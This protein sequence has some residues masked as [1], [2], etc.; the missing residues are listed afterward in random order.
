MSL[1]ISAHVGLTS[2]GNGT[3]R[4]HLAAALD[5]GAVDVG[6]RDLDRDDEAQASEEAPAEEARARQAAAAAGVRLGEDDDAV[7]PAGAAS[8]R[9]VPHFSLISLLSLSFS[10]HFSHIFLVFVSVREVQAVAIEAER[11]ARD[12]EINA[13]TVRF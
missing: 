3:G 9:E 13:A 8:G 4:Q 12:L 7:Q 11:S 1:V 2:V 10:R 6:L 5:V